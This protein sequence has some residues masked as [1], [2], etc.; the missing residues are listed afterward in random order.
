MFSSGIGPKEHL[1]RLGI[2]VISNLRVGDNL[3]EHVSSGI[4][5]TMNASIGI[6]YLQTTSVQN[7]L[8][9]YITRNN[10]L[11]KNLDESTAFVKTKYN[12][13]HDDWPDLQLNM[14]PGIFNCLPKAYLSLSR[15]FLSIGSLSTDFGLRLWKMQGLIKNVFTQ[16]WKPYIGFNTFTIYALVNRPK[17]RGWVRLKTPDPYDPP[18]ID[19]NLYADEQDLNV[20]VEGLK[21][22]LKLG[23]TESMKQWDVHPFQTSFPGCEHLTLYSDKYLRCVAKV[24]TTVGW[25][26]CCSNKMGPKSDPTAV[27]DTQL[28]VRGVKGLRVVD[29]SVMPSI[30]SGNTNAPTIMIAEKVADHMRGRRLKPFLPP[31]S[32]KVIRQLPHLEYELWDENLFL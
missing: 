7:I 13:P 29:A 25:H 10:S 9:Y 2:P 18:L 22:A 32:E 23:R 28:R 8:E 16:V 30:I 20:L 31:M 15:L 26:P 4:P 3:Q 19:P 21:F 6:D 17:S 5:F 14:M 1:S 12:S 27:V 24:Y 11:T